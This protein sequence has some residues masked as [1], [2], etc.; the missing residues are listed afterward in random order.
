M[1]NVGVAC[2]PLASALATSSATRSELAEEILVLELV[3]V[4]EEDVVVRP[5]AA[6][7]GGRFGGLGGQFRVLVDGGQRQVAED[8]AHLVAVATPKLSSTMCASERCC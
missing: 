1:K 3:L 6:L 7:A 2:A 5:E 4:L 8:R